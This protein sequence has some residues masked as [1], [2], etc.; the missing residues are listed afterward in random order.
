MH[1]LHTQ[2]MQCNLKSLQLY[3]FK[4]YEKRAKKTHPEWEKRG[5]TFISYA[6]AVGRPNG[7]RKKK[8]LQK[9]FLKASE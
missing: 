5:K 1:G 6:L 3:E 2:S 9:L 8:K 4:Q 7:K